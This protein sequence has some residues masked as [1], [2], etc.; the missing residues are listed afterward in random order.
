M[1]QLSLALV[2]APPAG[3]K[4]AMVIVPRIDGGKRPGY[5]YWQKYL[6]GLNVKAFSPVLFNPLAHL[7][8]LKREVFSRFFSLPP[9]GRD[10][11]ERLELST[12]T[13]ERPHVD[14]DLSHI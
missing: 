12:C 11:K 7:L 13:A 4:M 3:C 10:W 6:C 9:C 14:S 2:A 8:S 5:P 1:A